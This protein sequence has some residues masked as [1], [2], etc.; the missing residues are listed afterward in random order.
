[1]TSKPAREITT[2]IAESF[3]IDSLIVYMVYKDIYCS[4]EWIQEQNDKLV[5]LPK[6]RKLAEG[7]KLVLEQIEDEV[8]G[9]HL[10]VAGRLIE[11]GFLT[12]VDDYIDNNPLLDRLIV[13]HMFGHPFESKT[14]CAAVTRELQRYPLFAPFIENQVAKG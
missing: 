7:G 9:S 12:E 6:M 1:M 10:T 5:T 3:D 4:S 14:W 11:D 2:M 13:Y 8:L